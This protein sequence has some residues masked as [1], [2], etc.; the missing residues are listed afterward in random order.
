MIGALISKKAIANAFE[1]MNQHDLS[2][3]MSTWR[4]DGVFFYPGEISASG[5]FQ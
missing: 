4:D 5:T 1:A 3:F 2:K